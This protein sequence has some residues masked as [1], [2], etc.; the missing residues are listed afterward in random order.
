MII[1]NTSL[2]AGNSETDLYLLTFIMSP[3]LSNGCNISIFKHFRIQPPDKIGLETQLKLGK[4]PELKFYALHHYCQSFQYF[5]KLLCG[6]TFNSS[7]KVNKFF[8]NISAITVRE[9][10]VFLIFHFELFS[11]F[12]RFVYQSFR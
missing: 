5:F 10:M 2:I 7:C 11:L 9:F 6:W 8:L 1:S 3:D 4:A 12:S